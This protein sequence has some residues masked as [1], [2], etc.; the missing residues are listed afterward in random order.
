VSSFYVEVR[1]GDRVWVSPGTVKI[2][3]STHTANP[4]Q[5]ARKWY[6]VARP[7]DA[8]AYAAKKVAAGLWRPSGDSTV[9]MS[10]V[11]S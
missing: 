3:R 1:S 7:K 10:R 9:T 5:P 11:V 6:I 2:E 8:E 4:H